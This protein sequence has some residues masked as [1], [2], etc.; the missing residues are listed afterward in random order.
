M[1]ATAASSHIPNPEKR[2]PEG[3]PKGTPVVTDRG[4]VFIEDVRQ[5][6]QVVDHNGRW[7]KVTK[8]HRHKGP[9]ARI[10]GDGHPPIEASDSHP[11]LVRQKDGSPAWVAP[12]LLNP[13]IHEWATPTHFDPLPI[14]AGAPDSSEEWHLVG[15]YL[16]SGSISGDKITLRA[17]NRR[18]AQSIRQ[19][20]A[21]W[22][23]RENK[24]G[25]VT[26]EGRDQAQ[27]KWLAEHFGD[28]PHTKTVPPW[29]LGMDEN[30]RRALLR[31]YYGPE[32]KPL[33]T[34]SPFLVTGARLVAETLGERTNITPVWSPLR[35][36]Y[37]AGRLDSGH[38][39][40]GNHS[41]LRNQRGEKTGVVRDLFE[42][43]VGEGGGGSFVAGIGGKVVSACGEKPPPKPN[44]RS[45]T[46]AKPAASAARN[47]GGGGGSNGRKAQSPASKPRRIPS[48]ASIADALGS[49]VPVVGRRS[50]RTSQRDTAGV[51]P[52]TPAQEQRVQQGIRSLDG[53]HRDEDAANATAVP[54][55]ARARE[56]ARVAED[57]L[58][59]RGVSVAE[60]ASMREI[61][62]A[63]G[64]VPGTTASRVAKERGLVRQDVAD[65]QRIEQSPANLPADTRWRDIQTL[66]EFGEQTARWLE[67]SVSNHP[68]FYGRPADETA[69]ITPQLAALNRAGYVTSGSQPGVAPT[70]EADGT[71]TTQRAFVEGFAVDKE[72]ADRIEREAQAAGLDVHRRSGAGWRNHRE[73]QIVVGTRDGQ[74]ISS[75]G[76][77]SRSYVSAASGGYI[78]RQ[79]REAEQI[80]VVDPEYGRNDRLTEFSERLSSPPPEPISARPAVDSTERAA[81]VRMSKEECP[82]LREYLSAERLERAAGMAAAEPAHTQGHSAERGTPAPMHDAPEHNGVRP[83]PVDAL[84]DLVEDGA[85][86]QFDHFAAATPGVEQA[87]LH[88]TQNSGRPMP[89]EIVDAPSRSQPDRTPAAVDSYGYVPTISTPPVHPRL[90]AGSQ[91]PGLIQQIADARALR[92]MQAVPVGRDETG[93]LHA[94]N[95]PRTPA[96][97]QEMQVGPDRARQTEPNPTPD[98]PGQRDG[99]GRVAEPETT[100]APPGWDDVYAT[101]A[102]V[103][104]EALKLGFPVDREA[105]ERNLDE[106][107]TRLG[108]QGPRTT[109]PERQRGL[110]QAGEGTLPEPMYGRNR[111][112]ERE[113]VAPELRRGLARAGERDLPEIAPVTS[114]PDGDVVAPERRRSLSRPG[115][116]ELPP[117]PE[118]NPIPAERPS[119]DPDVLERHGL[120]DLVSH[121]DDASAEVDRKPPAQDHEPIAEP[122]DDAVA[123]HIT[124]PDDP[125]EQELETAKEPH[126]EPDTEPEA[127]PEVV[128]RPAEPE[129]EDKPEPKE[130]AMPEPEP[131]REPRQWEKEAAEAIEP[132]HSDPEPEAPS[133]YMGPEL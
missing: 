52:L 123:E 83:T 12:R 99:A 53:A 92:E 103:A 86:P 3:F 100:T 121:D 33:P 132:A 25:G 45:R 69:A 49:S 20:L 112:V 18:E 115:E 56:A 41:W 74:E 97:M 93:R 116:A 118:V 88:A 127:E 21:G 27:A 62:A 32:W 42:L 102:R 133:H 40:G 128:D 34:P 36:K 66:P 35:P 10:S 50:P 73:E 113:E 125:H 19:H 110:R 55:S 94:A 80:V 65:V 47:G 29:A 77:M 28:K 60:L 87:T 9:T 107:W 30:H 117:P 1:P 24:S 95:G 79:L 39:G 76:H 122:E 114:P 5:G 106:A 8:S 101:Q 98:T 96:L 11:V 71:T 61:D 63:E 23:G 78:S 84:P 37:Q 44:A 129:P 131:E 13:R 90:E 15:S 68:G 81:L 70:V 4:I 105:F 57:R 58:N 54:Q 124:V 119:H 22:T 2:K 51:V 120:A 6:D 26:F 16:R 89:V 109:P 91:E 108:G 126:P 104:A 43:E 72:T 46:T 17:A 14:P 130:E 48:V 31:G 111:D 64:A 59:Q 82:A 67:G 7:A 75:A 38:G 85:G